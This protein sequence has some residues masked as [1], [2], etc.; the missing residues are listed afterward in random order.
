MDSRNRGYSNHFAITIHWELDDTNAA[1]DAE[2]FQ[3]ILS[4]LNLDRA[5]AQIIRKDDRLPGWTVMPAIQ[6][7]FAR[8]AQRPGRSIVFIHYA[9]HG[10][11]E[12]GMLF[13][14]E[15]G[16]D[17][18]LNFNHITDVALDGNYVG[19]NTDVVF[20]LDCCYSHV[21][22]RA[23]I[24]TS[25]TIEIISATDDTTPYALTPPRNT[26]TRKLRA[27]IARRKHDGHQFVR[28]SEVMAS[29]R[30][31]SPTVKPTHH[32]KLGSSVCLPFTGI[33]PHN[34]PDTFDP[35]TR[36][37]FGV[38]APENVPK[39]ALERFINWIQMLPSAFGMDLDGVY[40]TNSTLLIIQGGYAAYAELA[41]FANVKFISDVAT[42]NCRQDFGQKKSQQSPSS[43]PPGPVLKENVPF[44]RPSH[45]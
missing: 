24:S 13:A 16:A 3:A 38:T 12:N 9:G 20:V 18:R 4:T 19:E 15:S 25:R 39:E 5:E 40:R 29:I 32:V 45:R 1:E 23:P 33:R 41:G 6:S 36:T 30:A 26:L 22:T 37:V 34:N 21:V 42:R 35:G 28:L 31:D 11:V 7:A 8:A 27:E 17:R 2:N 44:R 43:P 14:Q 10:D